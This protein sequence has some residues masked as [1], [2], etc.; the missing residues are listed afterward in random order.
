MRP[1]YEGEGIT[2]YHGE[3]LGVLRDLDVTVDAVVTDP[4][5]NSGGRTKAERSKPVITKY[6]RYKH[7]WSGYDGDARDQR[8]WGYWSALWLN[9]V[10]RLS[11]QGAYCLTFADWRQLASATDA[12]QAG[13]WLWRGT[14]GWDKTEG[15]R[16]PH[17]GYYRHQLEYVP[18]GTNG[19]CNGRQGPFPGCY[20]IPH[21][22]SDK[23]HIH[24]KPVSL[25]AELL[26]C[27]EPGSLVLDPFA[28]SGSTLVAA[29]RLG[30]RAIGIEQHQS[31]CDTVV[32]RL[33]EAARQA[34]LFGGGR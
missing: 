29:Q 22:R 7:Q 5:Y 19:P 21:K 16:A 13:G 25:M 12:L 1:Y 32:E 24:G 18:W 11:R 14:V 23:H 27:V 15:A 20:R 26:R 6:T 4:P 8:G 3:A 28:G 9:E 2:L 31:D 30:L 33:R 34:P 17:R 10:R